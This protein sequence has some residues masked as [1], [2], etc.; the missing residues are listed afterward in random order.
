MTIVADYSHLE[1]QSY[2]VS[3]CSV[4]IMGTEYGADIQVPN[5]LTV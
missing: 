5:A 2:E 3:L 4:G 1:S